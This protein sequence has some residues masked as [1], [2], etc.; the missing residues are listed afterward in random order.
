MLKHGL[1]ELFINAF[2]LSG[3]EIQ[4]FWY[5]LKGFLLVGLGKAVPGAYV[6]AYVATEHPVLEFAVMLFGYEFVFELYSEVRDT[7]IGID[8]GR[9]NDGIGG[10]G[11]DTFGTGAAKVFGKGIV[12]FQVEVHNKGGQEKEGTGLPGDEVG[13][14]SDP[15]EAG[16]LG[17]AALE[18]GCAVHESPALH[19]ADLCLYLEQKLMQPGADH[20]MVILSVGVFGDLWRFSVLLLF[21]K[22]VHHQGDDGLGSGYE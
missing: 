9:G 14:L 10:T 22:I 20:F 7:F 4:D 1:K 11:I 19:F 17:P 16:S 13:I 15:A 3:T 2:P 8:D 6:L 18:Y 12:V 5:G 21:R